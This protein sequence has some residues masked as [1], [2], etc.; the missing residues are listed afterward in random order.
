MH[1]TLAGSGTAHE[2]LISQEQSIAAA[3]AHA[4]ALRHFKPDIEDGPDQDLR[5]SY[6]S[7][8]IGLA[9]DEIF[10]AML[11]AR[12]PRSVAGCFDDSRIIMDAMRAVGYSLCGIV[13]DECTS[14]DVQ[15]GKNQ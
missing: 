12:I 4:V 5:T 15:K 1:D 14:E 10:A 7:V 3:V 9:S 8:I 2:P 11:A 6:T 13:N